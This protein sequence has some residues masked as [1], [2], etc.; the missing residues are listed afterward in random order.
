MEYAVDNRPHAGRLF[1]YQEKKKETVTKMED[2]TPTT[3]SC[4]EMPN[5]Y[6]F[7]YW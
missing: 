3:S 7:S 4:L 2:T 5:I 1:E 6:S